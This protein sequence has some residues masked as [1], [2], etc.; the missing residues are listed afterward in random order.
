MQ[1]PL[2]IRDGNERLT[3]QRKQ[4]VA[5]L[6]TGF[7]CLAAVRDLLYGRQFLGIEFE[8]QYIRHGIGIEDLFRQRLASRSI[9]R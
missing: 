1:H 2:H 6:Q 9:R 4:L 3:V 5:N 8:S 7:G